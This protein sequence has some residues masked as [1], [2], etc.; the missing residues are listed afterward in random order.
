LSRFY[1]S[2]PSGA[3]AARRLPA[4]QKT[5]NIVGSRLFIS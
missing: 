4:T 5:Y 1:R 3:L 2:T